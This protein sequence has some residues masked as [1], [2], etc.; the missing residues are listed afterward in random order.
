MARADGSAA[1]SERDAG[2]L[3]IICGGGTLPYTV[4]AAAGAHGRRVVLFA[5]RGAADSAM[6]EATTHHWVALGQFGRLCRLMRAEG[7]R[8]VVFIGTLL[9]PTVRQLRF[10]LATVRLLPRLIKAFRGGD[11]HLLSTV[12]GIF[13]D[14]GF[15]L[16]GAHEVAPEIL[17]PEGALG[18]VAP[19]DRDRADNMR[20]LAVLD[21]TSAFD[22]GQAVVVADN[23]VLAI[24][25]AEGT[26]RMLAN[27]AE[28]RRNGRLRV[29]PGTG[30]LVKAPKRGQD[31]RFDLPS[32]GPQTI[33]GVV[34]AGLAGVAA[35]AG[36]T[37]VAEPQRLA[38]LADRSNIFVAGVR[39]DG[40][41]G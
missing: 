30:V 37:I 11:D 33:E 40:T 34:R 9:R 13:E 7:C 41:V 38:E 26:D 20:G 8:D 23:R 1:E 4:A 27:L 19:S 35:A 2:S 32:L 24:E 25:A 36:S 16:L 31:R 12:A 22:I 15:R 17:L 10:D 14:H 6:V 29:P 3:A 28:L 21:A 18:R 5:V 39:N